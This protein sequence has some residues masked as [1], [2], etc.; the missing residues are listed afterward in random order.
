MAIDVAR[1]RDR[2]VPQN[3]LDAAQ[4]HTVSDHERR[5]GMPE[6]VES[7]PGETRPRQD[8]AESASHFRGA[9][10][11]PRFSH[12]HEVPHVPC[13][14]RA[15]QEALP[16]LIGSVLPKPSDQRRWQPDGAPRARC[17][18]F[19]AVIGPRVS[20]Q[21]VCCIEA[22]SLLEHRLAEI[23]AVDA[24]WEARIILDDVGRRDLPTRDR[25]LE[26]HHAPSGAP[27]RSRR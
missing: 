2:A 21:A 26:D 20:L 4:G 12:E 16:Q 11:L 7:L 19:V 9:Q 13:P 25:P 14:G 1:D 24:L 8:A 18:H 27:H 22:P 6:I 15:R 3:F 10:R 23:E 5:S 17:L